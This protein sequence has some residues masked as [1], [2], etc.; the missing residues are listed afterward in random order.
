YD[1]L[2][3]LGWKVMLPLA[4]VAMAW[5]AVIVVI[6][7]ESANPQVFYLGASLVMVIVMGIAALI[8]GRTS[9]SKE[10]SSA[11]VH[12]NDVEVIHVGGHGIGYVILQFVGSLVSV[13]FLLFKYQ[14]DVVKNLSDA[15]G[16]SSASKSET[17]TEERS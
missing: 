13:P 5:T 16:G 7:E 17:K 2:M 4:L 14:M 11:V 9:G 6:S 8:F 10:F 12:A 1:R 15:L 3:A